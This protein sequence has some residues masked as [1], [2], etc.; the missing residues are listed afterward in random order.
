VDYQ[1]TSAS[2]DSQSLSLKSDTPAVSLIVG[3]VSGSL[4]AQ[5]SFV[6]G[7]GAAISL[8]IDTDGDGK[9]DANEITQQEVKAASADVSTPMMDSIPL[10]AAYSVNVTLNNVTAASSV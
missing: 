3:K 9:V 8:G 6:A 10:T 2:L 1:V 7:T 4:E 5:V